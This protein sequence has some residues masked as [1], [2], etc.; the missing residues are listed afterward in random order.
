[1]KSSRVAFH[2]VMVAVAVFFA[3]CGQNTNTA[4]V[5]LTS[6]DQQVLADPTSRSLTGGL[7]FPGPVDMLAQVL[8]LTD[9]QKAQAQDIFNRMHTD[10]E[11]LRDQAHSDIRNVLTADQ[12]AKLDE[13]IASHQPPADGAGRPFGPPPDGA[14]PAGGMGFGGPGFGPPPMMGD[15]KAMH[16]A[17]LDNLAADLGLS[18][19]QKAQ[20]Q[21]IQENLH[22]AVDARRQQ[23]IGE[24]RAIL[25]ADQLAQLDQVLVKFP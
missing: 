24:L 19:D 22:A 25:T 1:M 12:Q 18:D 6:G 21:T 13:I 7:P 3:G 4:T 5:G 2:V 23:A 11:A 17:M 10:L 20:I 9:D 8:S 14:V 15:P 16:Q